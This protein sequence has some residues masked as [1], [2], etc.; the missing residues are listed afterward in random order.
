MCA[1]LSVSKPTTIN[2]ITL[3]INVFLFIS[4]FSA[5]QSPNQYSKV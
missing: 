2:I 1:H 3:L 4:V 5:A